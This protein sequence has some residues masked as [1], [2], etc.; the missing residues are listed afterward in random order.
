M[1]RNLILTFFIALSMLVVLRSCRESIDTRVIRE[2]KEFTMRECPV[3]V[4]SGF[5]IDSLTFD[6]RAR[7]VCY[8]FSLHGAADSA[9][10]DSGAARSRLLQ[11]V[12]EDPSLLRYKEAGLAFRYIYRSSADTSRVKFDFMLSPDDYQTGNQSKP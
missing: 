2:A 9:L 4:A 1:V 5:V 3:E 6:R 10:I 12:I 7:A 11:A 8:H